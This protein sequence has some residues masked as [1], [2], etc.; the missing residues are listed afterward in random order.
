MRLESGKLLAYLDLDD[1]GHPVGTEKPSYFNISKEAARQGHIFYE[2]SSRIKKM[3]MVY[4]KEKEVRRSQVWLSLGGVLYDGLEAY[5]TYLDGLN[6]GKIVVLIARETE[7]SVEFDV[8]VRVEDNLEDTTIKLPHTFPVDSKTRHPIVPGIAKRQRHY[9]LSRVLNLACQIPV[10]FHG[11]GIRKKPAPRT[12]IVRKPKPIKDPVK[13]RIEKPAEPQKPRLT[14]E[15]VEKPREE[16]VEHVK[17]EIKEPQK[18]TLVVDH[19]RK[20]SIF[21][22]LREDQD[23][24]KKTVSVVNDGVDPGISPVFLMSLIGA[25]KLARAGGLYLGPDGEYHHPKSKPERVSAPRKKYLSDRFAFAGFLAFVPLQAT[26]S[27]VILLIIIGIILVISLGLNILPTHGM[28]FIINPAIREKVIPKALSLTTQA[29]SDYKQRN[30]YDSGEKMRA[31]VLLHILIG[32]CIPVRLAVLNN[33]FVIKVEDAPCI[34]DPSGV[35]GDS[36]IMQFED[37]PKLEIVPHDRSSLVGDLPFSNRLEDILKFCSERLQPAFANLIK[38]NSGVLIEE[39]SIELEAQDPLILLGGRRFVRPDDRALRSYDKRFNFIPKDS[40]FIARRYYDDKGNETAYIITYPDVDG[41]VCLRYSIR[42][43]PSP[44]REVVKQVLADL[45]VFKSDKKLTR[46]NYF[47]PYSFEEIASVWAGAIFQRELLQS[48]GD[49]QTALINTQKI[50]KQYCE[51]TFTYLRNIL[52]QFKYGNS[53]RQAANKLAEAESLHQ[54]AKI[55]DHSARGE[56]NHFLIDELLQGLA[57]KIRPATSQEID[58]NTK[59]QQA[60][61]KILDEKLDKP[62]EYFTIEAPAYEFPPQA[63]IH[64]HDKKYSIFI[65]KSLIGQGKAA[66]E[67]AAG[68]LRNGPGQEVHKAA[69]HIE[70]IVM[71]KA[72]LTGELQYDIFELKEKPELIPGQKLNYIWAFT[73][74]YGVNILLSDRSRLVY[75]IGNIV[76]N[77]TRKGD[78]FTLITKNVDLGNE[79]TIEALPWEGYEFSFNINTE[80][81]EGKFGGL[82]EISLN[83]IECAKAIVILSTPRLPIVDHSAFIPP[84]GCDLHATKLIANAFKLGEAARSNLVRRACRMM[85]PYKYVKALE[86]TSVLPLW[87]QSAHRIFIPNRGE[88]YLLNLVHNGRSKEELIILLIEYVNS[89]IYRIYIHVV[90]ILFADINPKRGRTFERIPALLE[91]IIGYE[92]VLDWKNKFLKGGSLQQTSQSKTLRPYEWITNL[93]RAKG[94]YTYE[95][96]IRVLSELAARM[97]EGIE[98][99]DYLFSFDF[100]KCYKSEDRIEPYVSYGTNQEQIYPWV[101]SS[102]ILMHQLSRGWLQLNSNFIILRNLQNSAPVCGIALTPLHNRRIVISAYN[103]SLLENYPEPKKRCIFCHEST[104]HLFARNWEDLCVAQRLGIISR[105]MK[106]HGVLFDCIYNGGGSYSNMVYKEDVGDLRELRLLPAQNRYSL[107]C[108]GLLLAGAIPM[109]ALDPSWISIIILTVV[110]FLYLNSVSN[111]AQPMRG[112][113]SDAAHSAISIASQFTKDDWE[114]RQIVKLI[115][116]INVLINRRSRPGD[117]GI[118]IVFSCIEGLVTSKMQQALF[119]DIVATFGIEGLFVVYQCANSDLYSYGNIYKANSNGE[120]KMFVSLVELEGAQTATRTLL[121]DFLCP[122]ATFKLVKDILIHEEEMEK[123]RPIIQAREAQQQAKKEWAEAV[124]SD[125]DEEMKIVNALTELVGVIERSVA[126]GKS[127]IMGFLEPYQDVISYIRKKEQNITYQEAMHIFSELQRGR[128]IFKNLIRDVEVFAKGKNWEPIRRKYVLSWRKEFLSAYNILNSNADSLRIFS[129]KIKTRLPSG[130]KEKLIR[131]IKELTVF[132]TILSEE[133][134]KIPVE[135]PQQYSKKAGDSVLHCSGLLLAGAMPVLTN[136]PLTILFVLF[137]FGCYFAF[138]S[139]QKSL[140]TITALKESGADLNK[141]WIGAGGV[142]PVVLTQIEKVFQEKGASGKAVMTIEGE[143]ATGKNWLSEL[144]NQRGMGAFKPEEIAVIDTDIF[145]PVPVQVGSDRGWMTS[146]GSVYVLQ[147]SSDF[148]RYFD[149]RRF[150]EMYTEYTAKNKL[151]IIA[152]VY[153]SFFLK[154]ENLPLPI[155]RLFI[156]PDPELQRIRCIRRNGYPFDFIHTQG[157]YEGEKCFPVMPPYDLIIENKPLLLN[158]NTPLTHKASIFKFV[159][160]DLY[161]RVVDESAYEIKSR[162]CFEALTNI[163]LEKCKLAGL[164]SKVELLSEDVSDAE[165][166]V[167]G[168]FAIL[169]YLLKGGEKSIILTLRAYERGIEIITETEDEE[170]LTGRQAFADDSPLRPVRSHVPEIIVA[171]SRNWYGR[172]CRGRFEASWIP[173]KGTVYALGIAHQNLYK[174]EDFGIRGSDRNDDPGLSCSSLLAAVIP[175]VANEMDFVKALSTPW[176][177]IFVFATA[178]FLCF[179]INF[180]FAKTEERSVQ[181]SELPNIIEENGHRIEVDIN[182]IKSIVRSF[183]FQICLQNAAMLI[184]LLRLLSQKAELGG[185]FRQGEDFPFQYIALTDKWGEIDISPYDEDCDGYECTG[186]VNGDAY[187]RAISSLR[188][189]GYLAKAEELLRQDKFKIKNIPSSKT[190]TVS[191]PI[192]KVSSG[193]GFILSCSGV[194]FVA[195]PLLAMH[196]FMPALAPPVHLVGL[197]DYVLMAGLLIVCFIASVHIFKIL[198]HREA[199]TE[200]EARTIDRHWRKYNKIIVVFLSIIF[201]SS[202]QLFPHTYNFLALTAI[203]AAFW[204]YL[205]YFTIVCE[206]IAYAE[207][208]FK[209]LGIEGPRG[210]WIL[211]KL[212]LLVLLGERTR[213]AEELQNILMKKNKDKRNNGNLHCFVVLTIAPLLAMKDFMPALSP[214]LLIIFILAAV[215]LYFINFNFA[216]TM[217]GFYPGIRKNISGVIMNNM[218]VSLGMA[219]SEGEKEGRVFNSH[220]K[221]LIYEQ[222]SKLEEINRICRVLDA[223][224]INGYVLYV[225]SGMAP[226]RVA[227]RNHSDLDLALAVKADSHEQFDAIIS[228]LG[229]IL[230]AGG[231]PMRRICINDYLNHAGVKD[232]IDIFAFNISTSP[233]HAIDESELLRKLLEFSMPMAIL[234]EKNFNPETDASKIEKYLLKNNNL[235]PDELLSLLSNEWVRNL[236]KDFYH[237]SINGIPIRKARVASNLEDIAALGKRLSEMLQHEC[238]DIQML[239]S[240]DLAYYFN[241]QNMPIDYAK[242]AVSEGSTQ[243]YDYV[244]HR[245]MGNFEKIINRILLRRAEI[246]PELISQAGNFYAH[247][248][249]QFGERYF[250]WEVLKQI[251]HNSVAKLNT[252][253]GS[254]IFRL[255]SFNPELIKHDFGLS[256]EMLFMGLLIDYFLSINQV[257]G[258]S[259]ITCLHCH[260]LLLSVIPVLAMKDFAPALNPPWLLIFILYAVILYFSNFNFAETMVGSSQESV[261]GSNPRILDLLIK[262][263]NGELTPA[264]VTDLSRLLLAE[265][266]LRDSYKYEYFLMAILK[267][268]PQEVIN[269]LSRGLLSKN[270]KIKKK[271]ESLVEEIFQKYPFEVI[272]SLAGIKSKDAYYIWDFILHLAKI[273]RRS[274]NKGLNQVILQFKAIRR[275]I[276]KFANA[277]SIEINDDCLVYFLSTEGMVILPREMLFVAKDEIP[278]QEK[279]E[280]VKIAM[281]SRASGNLKIDKLLPLKVKWQNSNRFQIAGGRAKFTAGCELNLE[282]FP[283]Q[284]VNKLRFIQTETKTVPMEAKR[285]DLGCW[286][287]MFA[288]IPVLGNIEPGSVMALAPPWLL[289]FILAA[290]ILYFSNFNF[291]QTH[292]NVPDYSKYKKA[293]LVTREILADYKAKNGYDSGSFMHSLVLLQILFM[294]GIR[295]RIVTLDDYYAVKLL[296]SEYILDPLPQAILGES[297][298]GDVVVLESKE[299]LFRQYYRGFSELPWST[300]TLDCVLRANLEKI[301]A[302]YET[303]IKSEFKSVS[304]VPQVKV[305]RPLRLFRKHR[306]FSLPE[307]VKRFETFELMLPALDS[308]VLVKSNNSS[309]FNFR[310]KDNR[311]ILRKYRDNGGKPEA[312]IITYPDKF[313]KMCLAY[314]VKLHSELWKCFDSILADIELSHGPFFTCRM[315]RWNIF[316]LNSIHALWAGAIFQEEL[317][318]SNGVILPAF[319]RTRERLVIYGELNDCPLG[320]KLQF[321]GYPVQYQSSYL[322]LYYHYLALGLDIHERMNELMREGDP[323][324]A[325]VTVLEEASAR[326]ENFPLLNPANVVNLMYGFGHSQ[327]QYF[328]IAIYKI[329]MFWKINGVDVN[330]EYRASGF[331]GPEFYDLLDRIKKIGLPKGIF[332]KDIGFY[333]NRVLDALGKLPSRMIRRLTKACLEDVSFEIYRKK[334]KP[335]NNKYLAQFDQISSSSSKKTIKVALELLAKP[336]LEIEERNRLNEVLSRIR[337]AVTIDKENNPVLGCFGVMFAAIPVLANLEPGSVMALAPPYVFILVL[338][339]TCFLYLSI[340]KFSQSREQFY[341]IQHDFSKILKYAE[342]LH[343]YAVS[344]EEYLLI[345]KSKSKKRYWQ[346]KI[347]QADNCKDMDAVLALSV[348]KDFDHRPLHGNLLLDRYSGKGLLI[349]GMRATGK[350]LVS[351]LLLGFN[352]DGQQKSDSHW[353]FGA[354]D[355]PQGFFVGNR[356]IAGITPALPESFKHLR[357]RGFNGELKWPRVYALER[358]VEIGSVVFLR[359][360]D[361]KNTRKLTRSELID[362]IQKSHEA[363]Y[364][365]EDFCKRLSNLDILEIQILQKTSQRNYPEVVNVIEN[366]WQKTVKEN[367]PATCFCSPLLMLPIF[368]YVLIYLQINCFFV[369]ALALMAVMFICSSFEFADTNAVREGEFGAEKS[370]FN[371]RDK[372]NMIKSLEKRGV[373]F[374]G[375]RIFSVKEDKVNIALFNYRFSREGNAVF[376]KYINQIL[377]RIGNDI[378]FIIV[379]ENDLKFMAIK[380]GGSKAYIKSGLVIENSELYSADFDL[381]LDL[382]AIIEP[383]SERLYSKL[384]SSGVVVIPLPN[385]LS[386]NNDKTIQNRLL[387]KYGLPVVEILEA[388]PYEYDNLTIKDRIADLLC[389]LIEN[390]HTKICLEADKNAGMKNI[391]LVENMQ[392]PGVSFIAEFLARARRQVLI[393]RYIKPVPVILQDR[394]YPDPRYMA[395]DGRSPSELKDLQN[396]VRMIV[397]NSVDKGVSVDS[398][399]VRLSSFFIGIKKTVAHMFLEDFLRGIYDNNGSKFNDDKQQLIAQKLEKLALRAAG[400]FLKEGYQT[401]TLA[402]DIVISSEMDDEGLPN[403]YISNISTAF[404][405]DYEIELILN[406]TGKHQEGDRF[407]YFEKCFTYIT[408]LARRFKNEGNY[409]DGKIKQEVSTRYQGQVPEGLTIFWVNVHNKF[410]KL[411]ETFKRLNGGRFNLSSIVDDRQPIFWYMSGWSKIRGFYG[412]P[413]LKIIEEFIGVKI[414]AALFDDCS[415]MLAFDTKKCCKFIDLLHQAIS[416]KKQYKGIVYEDIIEKCGY[417]KDDLVELLRA[418]TYIMLRYSALNGKENDLQEFLNYFNSLQDTIEGFIIQDILIMMEEIN[419]NYSLASTEEKCDLLEEEIYERYHIDFNLMVIFLSTNGPPFSNFRSVKCEDLILELIRRSRRVVLPHFN[420]LQDNNGFHPVSDAIP[421]FSRAADCVERKTFNQLEFY[422]NIRYLFPSEATFVSDNFSEIRIAEGFHALAAVYDGKLFLN[423]DLL[424]GYLGDIPGGTY[425]VNIDTENRE[426]PPWLKL[427]FELCKASQAAFN[428]EASFTLSKYHDFVCAVRQVMNEMRV[429]LHAP[430]EAVSDLVMRCNKVYPECIMKTMVD[431]CNRMDKDKSLFDNAVVFVKTHFCQFQYYQSDI[432]AVILSAMLHNS[433]LDRTSDEALNEIQRINRMLLGVEN[434]LRQIYA[435]KGYIPEGVEFEALVAPFKDRMVR[436]LFECYGRYKEGFEEGKDNLN[437]PEILFGICFKY[438]GDILESSSGF[439]FGVKEFLRIVLHDFYKRWFEKEAGPL[440]LFFKN[441][442]NEFKSDN[443]VSEKRMFLF[444]G[445]GA[446][447]IY[448][449]I[450]ALK[451]LFGWKIP[452]YSAVVISR[453]MLDRYIG[454]NPNWQ[455]FDDMIIKYLYDQGALNYQEIVFVDTGFTGSIPNRLAFILNDDNARERLWNRYKLVLPVDDYSFKARLILST[456]KRQTGPKG[457]LTKSEPIQDKDDY[458]QQI[459]LETGNNEIYWKGIAFMMDEGLEKWFLNNI[460]LAENTNTRRVELIKTHTHRHTL[461]KIGQLAFEEAIR[462]YREKTKSG[463]G[464]N[465]DLTKTVRKDADRTDATLHCLGLWLTAIPILANETGFVNTHA[466]PWATIFVL[467]AIIFS[468]FGIFKFSQIGNQFQPVT[469][470]LKRVKELFGERVVTDELDLNYDFQQACEQLRREQFL[471]GNNCAKEI[472]EWVPHLMHVVPSFLCNA[473][474]SHCLFSCDYKQKERMSAANITRIFDTSEILIFDPIGHLGGGEITLRKDLAEIIEINSVS[475]ITTNASTCISKEKTA[476]FIN[477][478]RQAFLRRLSSRR[479]KYVHPK[480]A[481][482]FKFDKYQLAWVGGGLNRNSIMEQYPSEK[483]LTFLVSLDD[484]HLSQRAVTVEKIAN[485]IE[486]IVDCAPEFEINFISLK[487]RWKDNAYPQLRSEFARRGFGFSFSEE[488]GDF[489]LQKDNLPLRIIYLQENNIGRIGR[490]I[491]LPD[492][493]FE[494]FE[495]NNTKHPFGLSFLK[496]PFIDFRGDMSLVDVL[497]PEHS[498]LVFGNLLNESWGS[499]L[500]RFDKD[501]LFRG[502]N[503]SFDRVLDFAEEYEPGI[504]QEIMQGKPGEIYSFIYWLFSKPERKLYITYRLLNEYYKEEVLQGSSPFRRMTNEQLR[505]LVREQVSQLRKDFNENPHNPTQSQEIKTDSSFDLRFLIGLFIISGILI[506]INQLFFKHI[507]ADFGRV[508]EHIFAPIGIISTILLLLPESIH[509]KFND[510]KYLAIMLFAGIWVL[511]SLWAEV[512]LP[513]LCGQEHVAPQTGVAYYGHDSLNFWD[514]EIPTS[515]KFTHCLQYLVGVVIISMYYFVGSKILS[516]IKCLFKNWRGKIYLSG[517]SFLFFCPGCDAEEALISNRFTVVAVIGVIIV[518]IIRYYFCSRKPKAGFNNDIA[519]EEKFQSE[520]SDLQKN[521]REKEVIRNMGPFYAIARNFDIYGVLPL[522]IKTSRNSDSWLKYEVEVEEESVQRLIAAYPGVRFKVK[523]VSSLDLSPTTEI[524]KLFIFA[525][526][527]NKN[528]PFDAQSNTIVNKDHV[529]SVWNEYKSE[530]LRAVS[531][532]M[533]VVIALL[534]FELSFWWMFLL[535]PISVVLICWF[536]NMVEENLREKLIPFD[537]AIGKLR[538]EKAQTVKKQVSQNKL[539]CSG[540]LLATMPVFANEASIVFPQVLVFVFIAGLFLYAFGIFKF[541]QTGQFGLG[542]EHVKELFGPDVVKDEL[543]LNYGFQQR[544]EEFRRKVILNTHTTISSP[545]GESWKPDVNLVASLRCTAQCPHCMLSCSP[546]QKINLPIEQIDKVFCDEMP[547]STNARRHIIGGEIFLRTDLYEIIRRFKINSLTTNASTM[548]TP[549]VAAISV[550]DLRSA[551][552]SNCIDNEFMIGISLDDFHL[553]QPSISVEKIANL[554]QAVVNHF[555]EAVLGIIAISGKW[556]NA[557]LPQLRNELAKRNLFLFYNEEASPPFVLENVDGFVRSIYLQENDIARV[558]RAIYLPQDDCSKFNADEFRAM[559]FHN[560]SVG[561]LGDMTIS[562]VFI[563][564]HSPLVFGN[565]FT[566]GWPIIMSRIKKDPLFNSLIHPAIFDSNNIGTTAILSAADEFN[567]GIV[568]RI[569]QGHPGFFPAHVYWLLSNPERKLYTSFRLWNS[570]NKAGYV[571]SND[572]LDG[573][574]PEQIRDFAIESVAR[575]RNGA[576]VSHCYGLL[577]TAIPVLANET[578]F[579]TALAPPWLVLFI[580]A[581]L[582]IACLISTFRFAKSNRGFSPTPITH[583][584]SVIPLNLV[585]ASFLG[586]IYQW[587]LGKPWQLLIGGI[588][589]PIW[590]SWRFFVWPLKQQYDRD[591]L[592]INIKNDANNVFFGIAVQWR[593]ESI[594]KIEDKLARLKND[595]IDAHEEC[596]FL[597]N[598]RTPKRKEDFTPDGWKDILREFGSKID[599]LMRPLITFEHGIVVSRIGSQVLILISLVVLVFGYKSQLLI[600][601]FLLSTCAVLMLFSYIFIP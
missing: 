463:K 394:F 245:E 492:N 356:L 585:A 161:G 345:A 501:P 570:F 533:L 260:G 224:K 153:V 348:L 303:R 239:L 306:R 441:L 471:K 168:A 545:F 405:V 142:V 295:A 111:F 69:L 522:Y 377:P 540:L 455:G 47:H 162:S 443:D 423:A 26:H 89:R 553:S 92:K 427:L 349:F 52:M 411:L 152:G 24:N 234:S 515:G 76:F 246:T 166:V 42:T 82:G 592:N 65:L 136:T 12:P 236:S 507:S 269:I 71:N 587:P 422:N 273:D 279:V 180:N 417:K 444:L 549:Q 561:W 525:R 506:I 529:G 283:A 395:L 202:Y 514:N 571:G 74:P 432:Y 222:V 369:F 36:G 542:I 366:N 205:G 73:E 300:K 574:T 408:Y 453:S 530:I 537:E 86:K 424:S 39:Q 534:F 301:M 383:F 497:L 531:G 330:K 409:C 140:T 407:S 84:A 510:K 134:E 242:G 364:L 88:M 298:N 131:T 90:D 512:I 317:Q 594:E 158:E 178:V 288:A 41:V 433:E 68:I 478:L 451:D 247:L 321:L 282:F 580:F 557:A 156:K 169:R 388:L 219:I 438:L 365:S 193:K 276:V 379:D 575:L 566:E 176:M 429:I 18:P 346:E 212:G 464:E 151:V 137:F 208:V 590:E 390:G 503:D 98:R 600:L 333:L 523:Y 204:S 528:Y 141:V 7:N 419:A 61:E 54:P 106:R 238:P 404:L 541:A 105:F 206:Y 519:P 431:F 220:E 163:I 469:N 516:T 581:A 526:T 425:T 17:T 62:V 122:V 5:F 331:L 569:N 310:P 230:S 437:M 251:H 35:M 125:S 309:E 110:G 435:K 456:Q 250:V 479:P 149:Y 524:Y 99:G 123:E 13:E 527:L 293:L 591:Y 129:E 520:L 64:E 551:W 201:L 335:D 118:S 226:G 546:K 48:S 450:E 144:I 155:V 418:K 552:S 577:L 442:A 315:I 550:L 406:A 145:L 280:A 229:F 487:G 112:F 286:G 513:P 182:A 496:D 336:E 476:K 554:I 232:N 452:H 215:I 339:L 401:D 488:Q 56:L 556:K 601:A 305:A 254:P 233:E 281:E 461:Y 95:A 470:K 197:F 320:H 296:E 189:N 568:D 421:V 181:K 266:I 248:R 164:N 338:A 275:P 387:K 32:L 120:G 359:L 392:G 372:E 147:E 489:L 135:V 11:S 357:F 337:H 502:L 19:E 292:G 261:P 312:Y 243:L 340:F 468:C 386:L 589:A 179:S 214:P 361:S 474:C 564:G 264:E 416:E 318:N 218:P 198:Y 449:A 371:H 119:E 472:L 412:E 101:S 495:L 20:I 192:G 30:D 325:L 200:E 277:L 3:G 109:M 78:R 211:I 410:L 462:E 210:V 274:V 573:K 237:L 294:A 454:S 177:L 53:V 209:K 484:I 579:V 567:P 91:P 183:R 428:F 588:I 259:K 43:V 23:R 199:L 21:A 457:F 558:G 287:V 116:E 538:D 473:Y 572:Y 207:G 2:S 446:D 403:C 370:R 397:V 482:F 175:I 217:G 55:K 562:D 584:R 100:D 96:M 252:L 358:F 328:L 543:D 121:F 59:E 314:G 393:E 375:K 436:A 146:D 593:F 376:F 544:V 114:R 324:Y 270:Y 241:E 322:K 194:F 385:T 203:V 28:R 216:E 72:V 127:G 291:A 9:S 227:I 313:G 289:I 311:F 494:E 384:V 172:T 63:H 598:E 583:D 66:H 263:S 599:G 344:V 299:E 532:L 268:R 332:S 430:K 244:A 94:D 509:K 93:L 195:I 402:V 4:P 81:M 485:L 10:V 278:D 382:H 265:R 360:V 477:E 578:G 290:V 128:K 381:M 351:S 87:L 319:I 352:K 174:F 44:S 505:D 184:Y 51:A 373:A 396:E 304:F 467:A 213:A 582:S 398:R 391:A 6:L 439:S 138:F 539:K 186:V 343:K 504:A 70:N 262:R 368:I 150:L 414:D 362:E 511:G 466:P 355:A 187:E 221:E 29:L 440:F 148:Y 185:M 75:T 483:K 165:A 536:G 249:N 103:P 196:D 498:P 535:G 126:E 143:S 555:P 285:N 154:H 79:S 307:K 240:R 493:Y 445:R 173:Q 560:C 565:V 171:S 480:R 16:R 563:N 258:N 329:Y 267:E 326:D 255:F 517:L 102:D 133:K 272:I 33:H 46:D 77:L 363:G 190:E 323:F 67:T 595:F 115:G 85:T 399:T 15:R 157:I 83:Y 481:D 350:S 37:E 447:D 486:A 374:K 50:L 80:K 271:A 117:F 257:P 124:V 284:M 188:E 297:Y 400:A 107:H 8:K 576:S 22:R 475:H 25:I 108:S 380:G 491:F 223:K 253:P 1:Q 459:A 413:L 231:W 341:P 132:T 316:S 97:V 354:D 465:D 559:Q 104:H 170:V 500:R 389:I 420:I 225:V 547:N 499:A 490:A 415:Q 27:S 378:R 14:K 302:S 34:I 159:L 49:I 548:V 38:T 228:E 256:R 448:A 40:K 235:T 31:L 139:K 130:E 167:A 191:E 460:D 342:S 518:F 426:L 586:R 508:F 347:T 521:L 434:H 58:T 458:K 60:A 57:D 327:P 45:E 160:P 308:F 597:G 367:K 334:N 353:L 113:S 596:L